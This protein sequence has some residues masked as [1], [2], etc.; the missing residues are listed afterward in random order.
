[1]PVE[2]ERVAADLAEVVAS[3]QD[4]A[5]RVRELAAEV[6]RD[7]ADRDLLVVGVLNG[8]A[9]VTVDLTRALDRHVEISWMAITSYGSGVG[10]SGAV[11]LRKDLD[12]EVAG[13]DVL[14]VDGVL[15]TGLTAAWLMGNLRTRGAASVAFCG[16]FR[17]P[18]ARHLNVEVRYVGFDVPDGVVV[19]YGLDYAG[20]YRNLPCCA[21]LAPHVY[22]QAI[23]GRANS[24]AR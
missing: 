2:P 18:S 10:A 3:E 7:Y 4:I 21:I 23:S 14:I 6:E 19:G 13:R 9:V 11:R 1:V 15:D 12:V 16:M 22:D 20:H 8:A 17:K 5:R 24:T